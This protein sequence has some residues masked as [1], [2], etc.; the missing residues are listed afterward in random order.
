M[1]SMSGLDPVCFISSVRLCG[2]RSG[3]ISIIIPSVS[4]APG[5]L[6]SHDPLLS[7]SMQIVK[8]HRSAQ[9]L[10][11]TERLEH[12]DTLCNTE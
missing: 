8:S 12:V 10:N 9:A 1:I 5:K 11:I 6:H 3:K 7:V 4:E 2:Q